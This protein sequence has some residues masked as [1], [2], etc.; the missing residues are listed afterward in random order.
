LQSRPDYKTKNL[1]I[2]IVFIFKSSINPQIPTTLSQNCS[3]LHHVRHSVRSFL[4]LD[5]HVIATDQQNT[6]IDRQIT[7][8]YH[9]IIAADHDICAADRDIIAAD[10]G[11]IAADRDIY[12]AD[13]QVIPNGEK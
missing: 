9:D 12:A 2:L 1:R 10:R 11:I 6:A 3:T 8:A 5:H 4:A 13:R 7:A